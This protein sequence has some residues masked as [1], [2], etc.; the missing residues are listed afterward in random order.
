MAIEGLHHITLI[1]SNAQRTIDFY[2]GALGL[3][4]VKLTVNFDDPSSY[5]LYF[6]DDIGRPGTVVTFFEWPAASQG[7]PGIAGTHH[8]ALQ[9]NDYE[10]LL[11]WK[12]RLSDFGINVDGPYDRHY[13]NSIYF[14]DPDG[15]ILEIATIGPGWIIDEPADELGSSFRPPPQDML[16]RN[17]D[18]KRIA[19]EIWPEPVEEISDDMTLKQG[20][21]HITAICTDI[22]RENKFF[23]DLLAM[24][25]VKRT[26]N[27]DDPESAHWYWGIGDGKP[28]TVLTYFERK[29]VKEGKARIG[30]GQTH[31]FALSITNEE[32]QL[33]FREKLVEAGY[34]VSPV[35]DR[36]YFKSIYT[37]DPEGHIVEL[38]TPGPGF[39]V[40]ESQAELG[41]R[42]MLPPWLEK[43]R[44][45]LDKELRPVTIPPFNTSSG[46]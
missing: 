42:L 12:R 5:H 27:F 34:D 29:P 45:E 44:N 43:R 2:A 22:W 41:Q 23:S 39:L 25:L 9:V 10:N 32:E 30:R 21:H 3:R 31:H 19:A 13:F 33:E 16:V 1:C 20:L 40:D 18:E 7:R 24:R 26:L 4:L 46:W 28:G 8:F 14:R 6:G 38:A 17:R 11:K 35:L 37:K 15:A 36:V